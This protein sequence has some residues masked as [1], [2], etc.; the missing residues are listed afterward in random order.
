MQVKKQQHEARSVVK[1]EIR[2]GHTAKQKGV[3]LVIDGV[4]YQLPLLRRL[5]LVIMPR[6]RK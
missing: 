6:P 5:L 2:E 1:L 3:G 4:Y